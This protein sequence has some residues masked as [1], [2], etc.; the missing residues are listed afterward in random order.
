MFERYTEKARRTIFFARYEA[1][2]FGS[3]CI[4]SEHLLLGILREDRTLT[5][6]ILPGP[7]SVE[8]VRRQIK[9]NTTVREKVATSVDLP[10]SNESKR[11][12]AYG[13][14]EAERLSHK[15]IGTEHLLLGLLR[16][17]KCLAAQILHERGVRLGLLRDYLQKSARPF[18][19][20]SASGP[21]LSQFTVD[22]AQKAAG[23]Q[24]GQLIGRESE[25]G[26]LIEVLGRANKKNAVLVGGRGVGRTTIV[27]GL[28][29]RI[30]EQN[31]PAFL[32]E[33]KVL[34]LDLAGMSTSRRY[35]MRDFFQGPI[36]EFVA[37][38]QTIFFIDELH[39]LLASPPKEAWLAP[40]E[41]VKS[42]LLEGRVQC[43]SL[44][45][46]EE[47]RLALQR[48]PWL[49]RCFTAMEVN[50][51]GEQETVAVLR[52]LKEGFEKHHSVSYSD[53]VIQQAVKFARLCIRDRFLPDKAVDLI[54]EAGSFVKSATKVPEEIVER[55]RKIG[56]IVNRMKTAIANHELEKA[57]VLSEEERKARQELTELY[58]KHKSGQEAPTAVT[59]EALE[60]VVAHWTGQAVE[61]IR[62]AGEQPSLTEE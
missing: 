54:D 35:P 31:V 9:A 5:N 49:E 47:N 18:E 50:E 10:L 37:S 22:L 55:R 25:L 2:Q 36:A 24:P 30:A 42:A 51:P 11:V 57:R 28:A 26:R 23:G 1:S 13:A 58:A 4:E 56:F 19:D 45:T 40:A 12:L 38:P 16:E 34:A 3:P 27:H 59:R 6:Q 32:Q 62:K 61:E 60:E 53:E 7:D 8:S 21:S 48:H 52:A 15:H 20:A 44:A 17:E 33:R 14:E 41:I 43:I 39:S 46:P 29:Q